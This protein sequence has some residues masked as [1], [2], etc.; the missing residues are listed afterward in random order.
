LSGKRVLL[1]LN[2]QHTYPDGPCVDSAG[3]VWV[4][5]FGGW[6]VRC[7]SPR[8]K[9]LRTIDLPV[10]QCTK[11]AFGGPDLR[12]LYITTAT[13]GLPDAQRVQQ[14]L[15]GGLF[16]TRVETAGLPT[17]EFAG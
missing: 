1:Q 14:P 6:G 8:G 11:V 7:Y 16:R 5:M 17:N 15:A 2:E 3:N 10:A 12:T 9:L 4:A 13:V